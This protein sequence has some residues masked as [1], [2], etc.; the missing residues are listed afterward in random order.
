MPGRLTEVDPTG[1]AVGRGPATGAAVL[2]TEPGPPVTTS[3]E[4]RGAM[5][6]GRTKSGRCP[7]GATLPLTAE[8]LSVP[9]RVGAMDVGDSM[10]GRTAESTRRGATVE[11]GRTG[12]ALLLSGARVGV[13]VRAGPER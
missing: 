6:P 9:A 13:A 12:A 10:R 3:P 2:T 7:E 5:L 8:G 11:G 1:A 4:L